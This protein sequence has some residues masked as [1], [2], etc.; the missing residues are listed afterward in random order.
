MASKKLEGPDLMT[1]VGASSREGESLS[2]W[3]VSTE[4]DG[5]VRADLSSPSKWK[6]KIN[7]ENVQTHCHFIDDASSH[8]VQCWVAEGGGRVPHARPSE[9]NLE[10][11]PL[12]P[13]Q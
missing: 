8:F 6:R 4:Q 7:E 11:M 13:E 10:D 1:K 3:P 12:F 5:G 9:S 2:I